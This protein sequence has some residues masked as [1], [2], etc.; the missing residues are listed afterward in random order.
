M[1]RALHVLGGL[2]LV[3]YLAQA[4]LSWVLAPAATYRARPHGQLV[5]YGSIGE[6]V[7]A[8]VARHAPGML[9]TMRGV[10]STP[11]EA[12]SDVIPDRDWHVRRGQHEVAVALGGDFVGADW[13]MDAYA[14]PLLLATVLGVLA[15]IVLAR[16]RDLA[17]ERT[18]TLTRRWA[19]VNVLAMAWAAPV[20]V[21][22]FW[23]SFAWGRTLWWGG[24]PYY[25]VP[26]AA[27]EGL[28]FDA[29]I[30]KMT[31]G[32]LW[33]LVSWGV[34][35]VTR[36][37]V[38]WSAVLF[39][40]VLCGAWLAVLWLVDR[41]TRT[42]AARARAIALV[43]IGWLP[44]G[45]V[46]I[47]GDGHNDAVMLAFLLAW[48]WLREQ[49]HGRWATAALACSVSVKYV[50]APLFLLDAFPPGAW[51]PV[52]AEIMAR[53]KAY[54]PNAA[55]A[56]GIWAATFA[57]FVDSASFFAETAAVREGYFFLPSDGIKAIGSLLHLEL[58]PLAY[59]VQ[60]IFPV[61]TLWCL[62]RYL[63]APSATTFRV[64]VAGLMLTVLFIAAA[65][66]WPW[67]ALWLAVPAVLLA[68][69]HPLRRWA[70]GVLL[71]APFPLMV[72]TAWPDGSEFTLFEVPSLV[73]YAC[74][75]GWMFLA[76]R[77]TVPRA[78]ATASAG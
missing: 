17:D 41:L 23:L 74:A 4:A 29:P 38:W 35:A 5:F 59:A 58:R 64:A 9:V 16:H 3:A 67:Y 50:T 44:L 22:D 53:I 25:D 51:R 73:A 36:G 48:L 66:V 37:S 19:M 72:W 49:G 60:A 6:R 52:Q 34:A 32:P 57:P 45:A 26:A 31:Y 18:V 68:E 8:T 2:L 30:L 69:V 1:R 28:P 11:S 15:L 77:L 7:A 54:L 27:V 78:E 71:T 40:A 70:T 46:Q 62:W 14:L 24:N 65:H 75:L 56:L 43:T 63:R 10:R 47:G 20:L 61:A 33:A 12:A 21:P 42:R 39:K 55:I 76:W 13:F